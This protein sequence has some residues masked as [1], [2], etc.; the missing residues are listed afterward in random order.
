M[1]SI[2]YPLFASCFSRLVSLRFTDASW[3]HLPDKLLASLYPQKPRQRQVLTLTAKRQTSE[4]LDS[5]QDPKSAP[6]S[7]TLFLCPKLISLDAMKREILQELGSTL[8]IP[9]TN[10]WA[11]PHPGKSI[12]LSLRK[13]LND[14]DPWTPARSCKWSRWLARMMSFVPGTCS[15]YGALGRVLCG[16]VWNA[17]KNENCQVFKRG[18]LVELWAMFFGSPLKVR[19]QSFSSYIWFVFQSE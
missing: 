15:D 19:S 1:C 13:N 2:I 6:L 17:F 8:W 5:L 14:V 4:I 12:S 10:F 11:M 18:W 16:E 9:K 3:H 7:L